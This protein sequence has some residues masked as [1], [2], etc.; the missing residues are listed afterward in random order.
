MAA[1]A[2][3]IVNVKRLVGA[4]RYGYFNVIYHYTPIYPKHSHGNIHLRT[5]QVH[6]K[7]EL[8]AWKEAKAMFAAEGRE[9]AT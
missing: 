2:V 5:I 3:K 4:W 1:R 6:A 9:I 8:D 7:D